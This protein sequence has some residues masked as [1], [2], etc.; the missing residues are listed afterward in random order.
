[1]ECNNC[2]H[3]L[4]RT[5]QKNIRFQKQ[6][7]TF[8]PKPTTKPANCFC[9]CAQLRQTT[10]TVD[11]FQAVTTFKGKCMLIKWLFKWF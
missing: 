11:G 6:A 3:F 4:C 8:E 10:K 7:I 5:E 9:L 2:F 1:M